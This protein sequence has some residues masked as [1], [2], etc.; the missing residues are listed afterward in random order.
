MTSYHQSEIKDFLKL[1]GLDPISAKKHLGNF[2]MVGITRLHD[3]NQLL[4]LGLL[5]L[6]VKNSRSYCDEVTPFDEVKF[7]KVKSQLEEALSG[8]DKYYPT[9][10]WNKN[11]EK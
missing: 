8:K 11:L 5:N 2:E 3:V 4:K 10:D 7:A 6:E 1:S 9:L